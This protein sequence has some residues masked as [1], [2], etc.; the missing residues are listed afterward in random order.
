MA[1]EATDIPTLTSTPVPSPTPTLLPVVDA[2]YQVGIQVEHAP[3]LNP[4]NQ[5][6]WYRS[7]SGDLGIAWVKQQVRWDLMEPEQG[8]IDWS[9][10]DLIMPSAEKHA[11]KLLLSVVTAPDW[12]RE[13]GVDLEQHGPT[14]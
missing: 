5:D 14:G 3:D 2:R 8:D 7:V 6:A 10:L 11:I 13:S 4:D 12:A 1:Q 9:A